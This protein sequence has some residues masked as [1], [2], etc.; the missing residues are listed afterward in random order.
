MA[1]NQ[2]VKCPECDELFTQKSHLNSHVKLKHEEIGKRQCVKCEISYS[3][4]NNFVVH[5]KK[6]HLK[7]NCE[8][9]AKKLCRLCDLDLKNAK[10]EWRLQPLEAPSPNADE[11]VGGYICEI[12]KMRFGAKFHLNA[13][14]KLK[15]DSNMPEPCTKC[16][17][18]FAQINNFVV[19]LKKKHLNECSCKGKLCAECTQIVAD[20][21]KLWLVNKTK[22]IED[23]EPA[24]KT[25]LEAPKSATIIHTPPNSVDGTTLPP[26]TTKTS[27]GAK[28]STTTTAA[29]ASVF[30]GNI[31]L[32]VII[33]FSYSE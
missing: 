31:G 12:C 16:P 26:F 1:S 8:C 7:K 29:S 2:S 20:A 9:N 15:H 5:Y 13:H 10:I 21:K 6:V 32:P 27:F 4:T 3:Q 22:P 11:T 25:I 23:A 24:K 19:H 30:G 17:A 18:S 33:F 28:S 14:T